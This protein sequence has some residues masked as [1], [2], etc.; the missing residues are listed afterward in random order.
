M[1]AFCSWC[2]NEK[3][4]VIDI[5]VKVLCWECAITIYDSMTPTEQYYVKK[6]F[7]REILGM[8]EK[9]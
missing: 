3:E 8:E 2:V 7:G 9:K 6:K 5:G 1:T 4:N